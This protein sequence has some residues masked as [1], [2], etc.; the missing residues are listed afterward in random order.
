MDFE[1]QNGTKMPPKNDAEIAYKKHETNQNHPRNPPAPPPSNRGWPSPRTPLPMERKW[2]VQRARR[3][4]SSAEA[5]GLWRVDPRLCSSG[6][7]LPSKLV[8]RPLPYPSPAPW[9]AHLQTGWTP[10]SP[11]N[12]LP[13][14][15]QIFIDFLMDFW[16]HFGS[17]IHPK[18][19]QKSI[20]MAGPFS[21]DF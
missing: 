16:Y 10:V 17:Q 13:K 12:G 5:P 2:N 6:T 14:H 20:K 11:Q 1:L 4:P 18:I 21:I 9:L 8:P 3:F 7:M 19:H 15:D